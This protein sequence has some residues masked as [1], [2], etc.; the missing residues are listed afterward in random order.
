MIHTAVYSTDV[1]GVSAALRDLEAE[2][3]AR[4]ID[5]ELR[6]TALAIAPKR[7]QKQHQ[8]HEHT[9][10]LSAREL[11]QYSIM[12]IRFLLGEIRAWHC[13]QSYNSCSYFTFCHIAD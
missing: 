10:G 11:N 4:N 2:L 12:P 5:N 13:C 6:R 9:V 7:A 8:E 1:P 3:D